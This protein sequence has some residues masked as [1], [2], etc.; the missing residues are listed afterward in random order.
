MPYCSHQPCPNNTCNDITVVY[1]DV[2]EIPAME[3]RF[4]YRCPK[5]NRQIEATFGA[6]TQMDTVPEEA[7]IAEPV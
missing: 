5:C 4:R 2:D 6:Y 7:T 1:I 3:D